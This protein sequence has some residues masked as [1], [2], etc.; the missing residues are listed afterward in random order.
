[1]Y[2]AY[3]VLSFL[4]DPTEYVIRALQ[5]AVLLIFGIKF[6]YYL[7]IFEEF[8][9]LV[10]MIVTVFRDIKNFIIY[11]LILLAFMAVQI[12]LILT[13][14][15]G[16]D[17]IGAFKWFI[18]ALQSALLDGDIA[19][20]EPNT[21]YNILFWAV[22]FLIV[23]VGNIVLMNFIIAVVGDRYSNCMSKREA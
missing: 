10:Q 20:Y 7:R 13:D 23:L 2:I 22:W 6:N 3:L 11:F 1:M 4:Y 9:F 12:S 15:E 8:G 17:G 19:G 14:V 16:F 21:E 18:L 5:C